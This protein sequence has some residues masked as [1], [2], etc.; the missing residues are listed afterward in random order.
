MDVGAVLHELG[1]GGHPTAASATV[2]ET[3]INKV[4]DRLLGVLKKLIRRTKTAGDIMTSPVIS[5]SDSATIQDAEESLTRYGVNVLPV[6]KGSRL[7]GLVSR[8][9]VQRSL[10]HGLGERPV[11]EVMYTD[12]K[13][14]DPTTALQAVEEL[15]ISHN[16]R[17]LPITEDDRVIGAITRTDLLRAIHDNASGAGID[18]ETGM[19]ND[20]PAGRWT[21]YGRGVVTLYAADG[22]AVFRSGESISLP[23]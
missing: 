2:H 18:E 15:M 23:G 7:T 20:G 17:F 5:I 3:A 12:F 8:E 11:T 10:H 19:L 16:Q 9:V 4:V 14:A 6:L 22:R 1:G 21:V 13:T